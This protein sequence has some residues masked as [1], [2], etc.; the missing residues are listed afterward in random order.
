MPKNYME[1]IVDNIFPD[2]LVGY[3]NIC[4][5]KKCC[6]DIVAI[7]L[8]NLK[9][10]YAASDIGMVY[11]KMKE[12]DLQFTANVINEIVKAVDIVTKNPNHA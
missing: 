12:S 9:P 6:D 7:S 11:L 5:C 3:K 8:N 4:K 2:V 10:L 1:D